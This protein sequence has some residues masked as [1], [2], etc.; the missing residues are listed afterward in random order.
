MLTFVMNLCSTHTREHL[1]ALLEFEW[2]SGLREGMG[3]EDWLRWMAR[4]T[5][6]FEDNRSLDGIFDCISLYLS[7]EGSQ[8]LQ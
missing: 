2:M 8:V 3:G 7:N 6:D 5:F 1:K 4:E